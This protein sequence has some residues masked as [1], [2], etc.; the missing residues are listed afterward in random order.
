MKKIKYS[1][2]K[3][4]CVY[5]MEDNV[6]KVKI[7][8][9][10][11]YKFYWNLIFCKKWT[12]CPKLY[13]K[14]LG[15]IHS[16]NSLRKKDG[17]IIALNTNLGANIWHTHPSCYLG[18]QIRVPHSLWLFYFWCKLLHI[19]AYILC[20]WHSKARHGWSPGFLAQY[21]FNI[22][23]CR[24]FHISVSVSFKTWKQTVKFT[25]KLWWW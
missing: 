3:I 6:V 10:L 9:N 19:M 15:T 7:G 4:F 20:P 21:S 24:H 18:G 1:Q 23:Y 22:G 16:Q 17:Q 11:S 5:N 25:T 13:M 12:I 2:T 8:C 14:L